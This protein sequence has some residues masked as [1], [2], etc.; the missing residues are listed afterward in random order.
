MNELL[1]SRVYRGALIGVFLVLSW[2]PLFGG[3][4]G[5][6]SDVAEIELRKPAPL[7]G[8]LP[9]SRLPGELDAYLDDGFGFRSQLVTANSLLHLAIGVSGS[10]RYLVGRDGWLYHRELDNVIEQFRGADRFAPAALT[11]WTDEMERRRRWLK[12][13]GIEFLVVIAPS[14]QVIYPE[15]LPGWVNTVGPTRYDQLRRAVAGTKLQVLDLHQPMLAAKSAGDLLYFKTD[16]HWNDLGAFVAYQQVARW[17]HVRHPEVEVLELDDFD[18][19]WKDEAVGTISRGLNILAFA[20]EPVPKLALRGESRVV[21]TELLGEGRPFT[22]TYVSR[23]RTDRTGGFKV[24]FI[25]DSFA[26]PVARYIAETAYET[27]TRHHRAGRFDRDFILEHEPD[28]VIYEMVERGLR[29]KLE[30]TGRRR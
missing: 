26:T 13:Q 17:I 8:L 21:S 2:A 29:W 19:Q 22:T 28:L 11:R 1:D 6:G 23:V 24:L 5:I 4:L 30:R 9:L 3:T 16:G 18:V 12:K 20:T 7:P 14:K 10:Q 25:R 27:V 15:Y